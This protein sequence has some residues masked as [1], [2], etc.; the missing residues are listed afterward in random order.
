VITM[1][2]EGRVVDLNPAAERMFGYPREAMVGVP[3]AERIIPPSLRELHRAGLARYCATGE[4]SVLGKRLEMPAMR[5]DGTEFAVELVISRIRFE[6]PPMF[7][8]F[9][10][11]LTERK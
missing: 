2:S 1:D 3:M 7:T 6:G 9:I 11:D 5:A 10:R 4:G 8:G